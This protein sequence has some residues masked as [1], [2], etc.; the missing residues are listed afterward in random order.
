MPYWRSRD[1]RL[2]SGR[3]VMLI[4]EYCMQYTTTD[5]HVIWYFSCTEHTQNATLLCSVYSV[6]KLKHRILCA[7]PGEHTPEYTLHCVVLLL[8][9]AIN[10]SATPVMHHWLQHVSISPSV[11]ERICHST[12]HSNALVSPCEL[13]AHVTRRHDGGVRWR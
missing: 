8:V 6:N 11:I 1:E 7:A 3:F 10:Y 9:V 5:I 13:S 12:Q 4:I 2:Y